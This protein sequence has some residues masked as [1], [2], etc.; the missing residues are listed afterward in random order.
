MHWTGWERHRVSRVT[1]DLL[2]VLVAGIGAGAINAV[3]GSGT[4]ITFPTLVALGYPPIAANISN[5]LGLIPG[6]VS[7]A[8]GY[9]RELTGQRTRA[10][11]LA[12]FSLAGSAAGAVLLLWLPPD[13]FEVVVP[14]LILLALVLVVVQPRLQKVLAGH[15]PDG[16]SRSTLPTT[17]GRTLALCLGVLATGVYG[18]YFGAAQ[19]IILIAVLG[20][21]LPETLQRCNALKNLLSVIV[22]VVAGVVFL[23]VA[24]RQVDWW[25]V[26]AIAVGSTIGGVAGSSYG[27]R[28]PSW[29]L[30]AVIIV[31]G[32]IAVVRM[33]FGG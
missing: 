2:L 1:W 31:V 5:N 7:G 17:R 6:A 29:A 20:S 28:L 23:L 9:R 32:L 13:S 12:P 3:V 14:W 25:V 21:V 18:G 8:V 30:R 22:T 19:G 26:L 15:R 24:W 11:L 4:L 10:E 16:D 27:R 33:W